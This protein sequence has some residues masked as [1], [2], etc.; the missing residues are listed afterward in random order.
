MLKFLSYFKYQTWHHLY[1]DIKECAEVCADFMLLA[2]LG[3]PCALVDHWTR[4][5][6]VPCPR[7]AG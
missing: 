6:H 2:A 1:P 3:S 4:G 5:A 7:A